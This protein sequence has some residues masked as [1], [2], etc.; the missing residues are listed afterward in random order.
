MRADHPLSLRAL[1]ALTP[2]ERTAALEAAR[3]DSLDD[4]IAATWL[5]AHNPA[6]GP[7]R[8]ARRAAVNPA[9]AQSISRAVR[10]DLRRARRRH[11]GHGPTW[12]VGLHGDDGGGD[13]LLFAA[14]AAIADGLEP[15][16]ADVLADW[17]AAREP[18]P[19]V[20]ALAAAAADDEPE[21]DRFD[22]PLSQAARSKLAG[23]TPRRLQQLDARR[24]AARDAGQQDL[25]GGA[26]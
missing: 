16:T 15:S 17:A 4:A 6:Y 22:R 21:P 13:A 10:S 2:P 11:G 3:Y 19:H 12:A 8:G 14:A 9:D 24:R 7:R 26:S 20:L 23:L 18:L 1:G 25:F 5:A